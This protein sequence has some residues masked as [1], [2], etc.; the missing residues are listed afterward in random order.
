MSLGQVAVIASQVFLAAV[1]TVVFILSMRGYLQFKLEK[2]VR[3]GD[4]MMVQAAHLERSFFAFSF[5]FL[6][7]L[8]VWLP[9][10]GFMSPDDQLFLPVIIQHPGIF[11][12][13]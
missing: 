8:M 6:P 3:S 12:R 2:M 9:L 1:W 13:H 7:L 10:I 11:E 5:I 4:G